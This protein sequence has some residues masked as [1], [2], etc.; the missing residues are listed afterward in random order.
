MTSFQ[1][2]GISSDFTGNLLTVDGSSYT[3]G[4][5]PLSLPR[6]PATSHSFSWTSPLTVSDGKRYVWS[7]TTGISTEKSGAF[8]ATSG[9][10]SITANYTTQYYVRLQASTGGSVAQSSDW[11]SASSTVAI[12][13]LPSTGY[14]FSTWT[15]T[16]SVSVANAGSKDTTITVNG[17]G[18]ITASFAVATFTISASAGSGGSISPSGS[19]VVNYGANQSF[20]ITPTAGYHI[21][22]VLV[23]NSSVGAIGSYAFTN[24]VADHTVTASF[25][26]SDTAPTST[27]TPTSN[28][29]QSTNWGLIIG[30]IVAVV[31]IVF[32][33]FFVLLRR[34]KSKEQS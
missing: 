7:S 6:S 3:T 31:V 21:T 8:V 2:T 30:I 12:S 28:S 18:D 34:R 23:D 1:Q 13:A 19:V 22:D 9:N 20:T 26:L 17:S 32:I 27:S 29:P 33:I 16:G 15:V 14:K 24:I 11:Y 10:D 5:L 4:Q 25:A